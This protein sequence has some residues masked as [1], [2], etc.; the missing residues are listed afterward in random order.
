MRKCGCVV[1]ARA[2]REVATAEAA[3][4]TTMSTAT[5][6]MTTSATTPA[7]APT[8]ASTSANRCPHCATAFDD[9][10][11][12]VVPLNVANDVYQAARTKLLEKIETER[13]EVCCLFVLVALQ[14]NLNSRCVQKASRKAAA[15]AAT[16]T[17]TTTTT[18]T[19]T[20]VSSSSSSNLTK[21]KADAATA[22]VRAVL[23]CLS[24]TF[25]CCIARSL[26]QPRRQWTPTNAS[27]QC[28]AWSP[29]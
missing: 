19:S 22:K 27:R 18:T 11:R 17:T 28:P 4:T 2:I 25:D 26:R 8:D 20:N 6:P 21:R 7:L 10:T 15:T 14:R 24:G 13:R 23:Y 3:S 1:A 9:A 16:T 5:M 29:N 12:D